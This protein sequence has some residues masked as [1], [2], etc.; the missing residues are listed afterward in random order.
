MNW[1]SAVLPWQY[2]QRVALAIVATGTKFAP[3][4]VAGGILES[5]VRQ[6]SNMVVV[7]Q[8][9]ESLFTLWSW[10]TATKLHLHAVD[11]EEE[12]CAGAVRGDPEAFS[13][14]LDFDLDPRLESVVE[15]VM[16]KNPLACYVALQMTQIG[17][18]VPEVC[19]RGF[20]HLRVLATSGRYDHVM[21][22]I[23]NLTP[24]FFPAP[25]SVKSHEGFL[26]TLSMI[27]SADQTVYKIAKELLVA[28]SPGPVMKEFG[29]MVQK[30]ISSWKR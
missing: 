15:G 23:C 18:S 20:D 17:H 14:I 11:Q 6:I 2:H 30:Q 4:S 29:N 27:T 19:G 21:E 12:R 26:A 25:E 24:L 28:D 9:P 5:S 16:A 7:R 13:R 3:D 10:E 8:T 1:D 22:C